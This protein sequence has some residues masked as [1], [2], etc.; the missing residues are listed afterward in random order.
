MSENERTA[1]QRLEVVVQWEAVYRLAGVVAATRPLEEQVAEIS[2]AADIWRLCR[3]DEALAR[4]WVLASEGDPQVVARCI[5]LGLEPEQLG[6]LES[7]ASWR[8]VI[9]R[10]TD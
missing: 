4:R 8:S 3:R 9:E 2:A 1:D 5:V 6:R 7:A 10:L